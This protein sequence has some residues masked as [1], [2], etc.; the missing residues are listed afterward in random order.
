MSLSTGVVGDERV[1]CYKVQELGQQTFSNII[2][3]NF[4]DVK[5]KRTN[6]V[7]SLEVAN[8]KHLY[9]I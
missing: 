3:D 9:Q 4:N 2:G 5:L 8:N 1:N 6:C 7:V